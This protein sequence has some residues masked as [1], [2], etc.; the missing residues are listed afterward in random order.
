V[1]E[2][3]LPL[4]DENLAWTTSTGF[5]SL[6]PAEAAQLSSVTLTFATR[7]VEQLYGFLTRR[8]GAH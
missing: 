1:K 4:D 5:L 6:S 7:F 2:V 3:N 8:C